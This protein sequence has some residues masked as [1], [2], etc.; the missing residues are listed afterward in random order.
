M[1]FLHFSIYPSIYWG[2]LLYFTQRAP[3]N[4]ILYRAQFIP[5]LDLPLVTA[6]YLAFLIVVIVVPFIVSL[7]SA[8]HLMSVETRPG[9]L[10]MVILSIMALSIQAWV[11]IDSN[12]IGSISPYISPSAILPVFS[13]LLSSL[14]LFRFVSRWA[15]LYFSVQPD[16]SVQL[17]F[18]SNRSLLKDAIKEHSTTPLTC[19][20]S[21]ND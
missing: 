16:V 19:Y 15:D 13:I 8:I 5:S 1:A 11:N 2:R 4:G 21:H 14:A 20:Q 7:M 17:L 3:S 12:H 9:W 6:I 10:S 18:S